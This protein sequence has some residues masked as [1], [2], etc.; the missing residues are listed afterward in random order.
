MQFSLHSS[1]HITLEKEIIYKV[2]NGT[3]VRIESGPPKFTPTYVNNNIEEINVRNIY[4][5]EERR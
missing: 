5:E 3:A 4:E 1:F 2:E